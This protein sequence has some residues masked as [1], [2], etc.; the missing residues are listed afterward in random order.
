[1]IR[2]T[3]LQAMYSIPPQACLQ[4][5][6]LN[7]HQEANRA[8]ILHTSLRAECFGYREDKTLEIL[9]GTTFNKAGPLLVDL[10]PEVPL[11]DVLPSSRHSQT[12]A[13]QAV[14]PS[15]IPLSLIPMQSQHRS[16][17]SSSDTTL[18]SAH[19][20]NDE[21]WTAFQGLHKNC[22]TIRSLKYPARFEEKV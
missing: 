16:Y 22:Q 8:A 3:R 5:H 2:K 15:G 7:P 20:S 21:A 10:H 12:I 14:S 11:Q 9:P 6:A 18:L 13:S 17:H 1:M 4:N 19:W